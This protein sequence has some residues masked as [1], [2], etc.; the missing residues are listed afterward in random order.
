MASKRDRR[1]GPSGSGASGYHSHRPDTGQHLRKVFGAI[2]LSVS[3]LAGG[4]AN[5][6]PVPLLFDYGYGHS[7]DRTCAPWCGGTDADATIIGIESGVTDGQF[8]GGGAANTFASVGG[9]GWTGKTAT[10]AV[11]LG[12]WALFR[13]DSGQPIQD[14]ADLLLNWNLNLLASHDALLGSAGGGA[15]LYFSGWQCFYD[16]GCGDPYFEATMHFDETVFVEEQT[17]L[18]MLDPSVGYGIL[19]VTLEVGSMVRTY[20]LIGIYAS[21][22]DLGTF[23]FTFWAD[24]GQAPPNP[25]PEPSGTWLIP[26]GLA[27]LALIR[28]G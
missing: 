2:A 15:S 8:V 16:I 17:A 11:S 20:P 27:M 24:D 3:V 25:T 10:A 7:T 28:R 26:A 21:A 23:D 6:M 9:G 18:G 14:P 1:Q 19:Q 22:I 4:A 13:V 5:A 12:W